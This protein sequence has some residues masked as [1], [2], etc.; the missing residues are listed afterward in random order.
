VIGSASRK[1]QEDEESRGREDRKGRNALPFLLMGQ[2][3]PFDREIK[4]NTSFADSFMRA[5]TVPDA[6]PAAAVPRTSAAG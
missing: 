3:R 6:T 1:N 5:I 2:F 4:G